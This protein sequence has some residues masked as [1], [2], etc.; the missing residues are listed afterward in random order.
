[1]GAFPFMP[2]ANIEALFE[3]LARDLGKKLG[4]HLILV[5]SSSFEKFSQQLQR[6]AFHVAFVHPFDYVL[7][8]KPAGYLPLA[9]RSENLAS[10]FVTKEG[11]PIKSFS[12]LKGK[13]LGN[14]PADATVSILN[15]IT[16]KSEGLEAGSD[17]EVRY[18]KSH[19]ACM[20][21]LAIG[22]VDAC[23][24]S[25]AIVRLA[26]DQLQTKFHV[27]YKSPVISAPL[28]VVRQDLPRKEQETIRNVLLATTLKDVDP[29][30]RKMF[31]PDDRRKPFIPV[32]D[33]DYDNARQLLKKQGLR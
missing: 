10:H 27:F 13:M 18:F 22:S 9:A 4:K 8:A 24:V 15:R 29:A 16:L 19:M 26:E 12:G 6:R 20:Q 33:S 30:L 32:T 17:V 1:M 3:P 21:Q 14:P 23:G 28:F 25:P 7:V 11:S 31:V 2:V 5:S